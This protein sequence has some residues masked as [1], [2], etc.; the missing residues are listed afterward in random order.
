V[1]PGRRRRRAALFGLRAFRLLRYHYLSLFS[2]AVLITLAVITLR[3]ADRPAQAAVQ[4][5][6]LPLASEYGYYIQSIAWSPP[7]A[8]LGLRSIVYYIY[9]TE[10]QYEVMQSGIALLA[11]SRFKLDEGGRR[12]PT[13][14]SAPLRRSSRPPR[15]RRSSGRRSWRGC[16]ATGSKSSICARRRA[17]EPP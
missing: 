5:D 8:E 14:S 15:S 6:Q 9:E 13:S 4:L 12:T 11:R 16:R 17:T 1:K 7:A 2:A 3:S 10:Q